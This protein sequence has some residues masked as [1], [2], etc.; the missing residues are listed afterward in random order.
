MNNLLV[1][2]DDRAD[3]VKLYNDAVSYSNISKE[4]WKPNCF[5]NYTLDKTTLIFPSQIN[6]TIYNYRFWQL[7][8]SRRQMNLSTWLLNLSLGQLNS[9]LCMKI[10]HDWKCFKKPAM[11]PWMNLFHP[12]YEQACA[13]SEVLGNSP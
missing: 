10:C 13:S 4:I 6:F 1:K 2:N 3:I 12:H 9:S 11:R 5:K 8:S 7:N